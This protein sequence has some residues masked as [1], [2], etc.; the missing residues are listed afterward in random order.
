[1]VDYVNEKHESAGNGS[2]WTPMRRN[3]V[4]K[5]VMDV[6]KIFVDEVPHL[7]VHV[8]KILKIVSD[9]ESD[10]HELAHISSSDPGMVSKLLKQW[11]NALAMSRTWM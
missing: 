6:I 11:T 5:E 3:D 4:T 2:P 9:I 7:P 1:M 8:Y 10:S